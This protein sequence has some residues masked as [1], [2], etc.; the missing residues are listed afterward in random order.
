MDLKKN[1]PRGT[2]KTLVDDAN[3]LV[4]TQWVDSKVVNCITTLPD[5][6]DD[7]V[8]RRRGSD[9][10]TVPCPKCICKYQRTM[11]G[12]DKGDQIRMHGGGFARKAHFKK[13]Y[14]KIHLGI[15]DI[16]LMNSYIGWNMAAGKA[17]STKY[18]LKRWE[19]YTL[20]AEYMLNFKDPRPNKLAE[21]LQRTAAVSFIEGEVHT[22]FQIVYSKMPNAVCMVCKLESNWGLKK[23]GLQKNL[24]YCGTCKLVAHTFIPDPGDD[25]N[26]RLIHEQPE[27]VDKTCWQIA[28]EQLAKLDG[29][30]RMKGQGPNSLNYSVVTS[31]PIYMRLKAAHGKNPRKKRRSREE[32]EAAHLRATATSEDQV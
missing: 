22:P 9:S 26:R 5:L 29:I 25:S 24:S 12:V 6:G 17:G 1:M 30:W 19:F 11:F 21:S 14:K 4:A 10:Q 23:A 32:I 13:R 8:Q 27:C 2:S 18:H 7:E 28:H 15:L 16:M 31:N 3:R 20:I